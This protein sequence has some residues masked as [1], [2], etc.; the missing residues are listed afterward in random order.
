MQIETQN[1]SRYF[2]HCFYSSNNCALP[3]DQTWWGGGGGGGGQNPPQTWAPIDPVIS[4]AEERKLGSGFNFNTKAWDLQKILVKQ[5]YREDRVND[6]QKITL[7]STRI[8]NYII[9][10]ISEKDSDDANKNYYDKIYEC[11]ISI[12]SECFSSSEDD[13]TPKEKLNLSKSRRRVR[14]IEE[15]ENAEK[16]DKLK[17]IPIPFC[18]F[19][20]T[21][22]DVITS[23]ACPNSLPETKKKKIVLVVL[24]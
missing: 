13:C 10:I 7:Y 2:R 12:E 24:L 15:K 5:K 1:N 9:N 16:D 17:D 19:N 3:C 14:N 8:T 21:N 6:G 4:E 18:L 20:L 11:S 23:I 22:N